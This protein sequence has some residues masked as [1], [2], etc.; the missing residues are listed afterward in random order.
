MIY[1]YRD[2]RAEPGRLADVEARFRNHTIGLFEKHG[3]HNVG[4]WTPA[5][6]SNDRLVYIVSF[7]SLEHREK[8]WSDFRADPEWKQVVTDSEINGP[9]VAE[10]ISIIL[11]PTDYSPLQ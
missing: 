11:N 5:T 6:D 1:E 2:Y 4:Y 8:A 9:I 3:F 7:K 10:V